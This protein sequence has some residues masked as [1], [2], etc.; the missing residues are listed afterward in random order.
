[1]HRAIEIGADDV[2]VEIADHEQRRIQ[3]RFP[4]TEQLT[5]G[6]VEVLFLALVFPGEAALFPHVRKAALARFR[7]LAGI[8]E[9][10]KLDVFDDALLEAEELTRRVRFQRGWDHEQAAQVVEMGLVRGGFLSAHLGPFRFELRRGHDSNTL[11]A[12]SAKGCDD[13]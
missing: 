5:V 13:I 12:L 1:L 2:A 9:H 10:E 8:I 3:Q 6:L 11:R 7:F 4:V